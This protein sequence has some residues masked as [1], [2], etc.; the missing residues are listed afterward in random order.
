MMNLIHGGDWAGYE[1]EYGK[2]PLDFSAN[3]SPLGI[4]LSVRSAVIREL[5]TA[6]RYPDPLCRNL[7]YSLSVFHSI[8]AEQI[9]CGNGASDLIDRLCRSMQPKRAAVF[10]PGFAEY[11]RAL[12]ALGC[13]MKTISLPEKKDYQLTET[14]LRQIPEG[15]ELLFLCNPNNPTGL[16]TGP[17]ILEQLLSLCRETGMRLVV[18]ECFLDFTREPERFSMIKKLPKHPELVILRAFTKLWGMAGLRLGYALCGSETVAEQLCNCGQPWPVSGLAQ[19]AGVAALEEKDYVQAVRELVRKERPRMQKELLKMG[20]RV[21][22]G[23]AN[24]LL[25][26]SGDP[27]LGKKLR[28]RGILLRDCGNFQA[29]CPGWYRT[30]IRTAEENDILLR[31]LWEVRDCG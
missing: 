15:C 1:L 19:A 12:Q 14:E 17:E 24:F 2:T 10:V 22:R 8:P 4:P 11:E 7:R 3:I 18:D 23:E 26:D 5:G 30:A 13:E 29:L 6:D 20:F 16:L 9:V 25:F 28:E 27:A 31:T 21:I